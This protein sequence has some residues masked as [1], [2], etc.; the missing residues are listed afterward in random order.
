MCSTHSVLVLNYERKYL[1][2]VGIRR[3]LF[4]DTYST[5]SQLGPFSREA[6]VQ[7]VG[8]QEHSTFLQRHFLGSPADCERPYPGVDLRLLVCDVFL[9]GAV[10]QWRYRPSPVRLSH[11]EVEEIRVILSIVLNWLE[12]GG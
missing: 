3:R 10:S 7:G 1:P 4:V 11:F 5:V 12:D 6:A 9:L 8:L 2:E